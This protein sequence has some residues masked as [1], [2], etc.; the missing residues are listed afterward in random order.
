M[1][2]RFLRGLAITT[3]CTQDVE[4]L[5]SVALESPRGGSLERETTRE[6]TRKLCLRAVQQTAADGC[7]P[8]H[9][10]DD[11]KRERSFSGLRRELPPSARRT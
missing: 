11:R 5:L 2:D 4:D 3:R 1:L 8:R 7:K 10:R 9:G 6:T